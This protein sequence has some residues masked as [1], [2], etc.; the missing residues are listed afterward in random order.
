M[1]T[2]FDINSSGTWMSENSTPIENGAAYE[3]IMRVSFETEIDG[4]YTLEL[5]SFSVSIDETS[6]QTINE[7]LN[8]LSIS[9]LPIGEVTKEGND[10]IGFGSDFKASNGGE[11][12]HLSF[13]LYAGAK[14]VIYPA[15]T[16]PTKIL[17][18]GL[19]LDFYSFRT[20]ENGVGISTSGLSS[21]EFTP[22]PEIG[23]GSLL[24]FGVA[25]Y[26]IRRARR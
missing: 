7:N 20:T 18:S 4:S 1:I 23:S 24:L 17:E 22:V 12:L 13:D 11:A 3:I 19:L 15:D 2:L 5:K 21:I 6:Y 14:S 26:L 10:L 8:I 16:T 9:T 25:G